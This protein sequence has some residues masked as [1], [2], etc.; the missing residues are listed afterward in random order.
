MASMNTRTPGA[1]SAGASVSSRI[2][3]ASSISPRPIETRPISLM[4]ERGPLRNAT[5]PM[6]NSTGATAAI[7][8][9][10]SLHD[11]RGADIGAEHDR[12]RRHQAD[13]SFRGERAR[14]Q[15]GG[16]AALEQRGE[17]EAGGKG[18]EAVVQRLRQQQPQVGTER[19][20]DSAVDHMQ[21]PQQQRHAAHQIE[22]NH[23]SHDRLLP[24]HSILRVQA[25]AKLLRINNLLTTLVGR[26]RA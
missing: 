4:R 22:Q 16:G 1:F 18:G 17:A 15:R 9:D 25:R 20:Q 6:M 5:R 3:S 14:D 21:A 11:Q 19:A 7:L 10:R 23:G 12:K 13:Q 24:G 8:N 26:C 2:C